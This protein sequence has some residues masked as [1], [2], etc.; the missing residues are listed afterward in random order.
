MREESNMSDMQKSSVITVDFEDIEET[1][2][3]AKSYS[4]CIEYDF[5]LSF[6]LELKKHLNCH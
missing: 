2:V 6:S 5:E 3:F 4:Y 1:A